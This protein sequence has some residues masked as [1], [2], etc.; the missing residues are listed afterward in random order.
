MNEEKWMIE[1]YLTT[2][3]AWFC[4]NSNVNS[5]Q[6]TQDPNAAII[7]PSKESAEYVLS[8]IFMKD[9]IRFGK[10]NGERLH[11]DLKITSHLWI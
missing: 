6:F 1:K 4:G 9:D 8:L 2:G 10:G 5:L 3:A 7:F 11:R